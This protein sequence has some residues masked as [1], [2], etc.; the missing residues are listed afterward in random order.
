VLANL[1]NESLGHARGARMPVGWTEEGLQVGDEALLSIRPEKMQL[2]ESHELSE[3]G[4]TTCRAECKVKHLVY[5]GTDTRHTIVF[6]NGAEA[7]VRLQNIYLDEEP[8]SIG[9]TAIVEWD[10]GHARLLRA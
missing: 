6:P 3:P 4:P 5:V 10:A 9:E 7:V 2:Y 1:A 8:W